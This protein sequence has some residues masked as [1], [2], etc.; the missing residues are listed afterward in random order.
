[1]EVVLAV[2]VELAVEVGEAEA[3][4]VELEVLLEVLVGVSVTPVAPTHK[5]ARSIKEVVELSLNPMAPP[6]KKARSNNSIIR[7]S[8]AMGSG[9]FAFLFV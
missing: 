6:N 4:L 5:K 9:A 1:M 7:I 3:L 8:S 2:P